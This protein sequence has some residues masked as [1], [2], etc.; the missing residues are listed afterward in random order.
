MTD[1]EVG[2]NAEVDPP[3]ERDMPTSGPQINGVSKQMREATSERP[4]SEEH[5]RTRIQPSPSPFSRYQTA[6]EHEEGEGR[7]RLPAGLTTAD[8]KTPAVPGRTLHGEDEPSEGCC[9]CV[10]M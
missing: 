3:T 8:V 4:G 2:R 5:V 10:I 7:S 9:K 6:V 1:M